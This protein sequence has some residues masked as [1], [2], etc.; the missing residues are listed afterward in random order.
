VNGD[1]QFWQPNV[2]DFEKPKVIKE[3]L[4]I[5]DR[6]FDETFASQLL[7]NFHQGLIRK[8]KQRP[9]SALISSD[10]V[11]VVPT[12]QKKTERPDFFQNRSILPV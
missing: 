10:S 6:A 4:N 3:V 8:W 9:Q 1:I 12:T 5:S 11:L 7:S 2:N